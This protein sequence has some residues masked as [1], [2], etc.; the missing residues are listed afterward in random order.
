MRGL[1]YKGIAA[2]NSEYIRQY[3]Q[4]STKPM[5]MQPKLIF[6]QDLVAAYTHLND[7]ES[8]CRIIK[9]GL[10]MYAQNSGLRELNQLCN[11]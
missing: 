3:I 11:V 6:F 5:A 1:L 9:S 10:E 8:R 4:W 2:N 7:H